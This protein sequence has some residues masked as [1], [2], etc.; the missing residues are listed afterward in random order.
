MLGDADHAL[1]FLNLSANQ[2]QDTIM[3]LDLCSITFATIRVSSRWS[4]GL[5]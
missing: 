4:G 3:Y 2:R 5:A 1:E